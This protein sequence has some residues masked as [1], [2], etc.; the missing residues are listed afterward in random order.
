MTDTKILQGLIQAELKRAEEQHPTW[1]TD[2]F[3]QLAIIGEEFGELQQAVLQ[4][5]HEGGSFESIQHEGIQVAAMVQRFLMGISKYS[6][7]P[8]VS[9]MSAEQEKEQIADIQSGL[10]RAY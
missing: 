8:G 3:E 9:T 2:A 6:I 7:K 10:R 4:Y 5:K 1:P